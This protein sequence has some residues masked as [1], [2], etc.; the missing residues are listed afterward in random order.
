MPALF[1]AWAAARRD[2]ATCVADWHN[3]GFTVLEDVAKRAGRETAS[4][5]FIAAA[6]FFCVDIPQMGSRRRRDIE[7]RWH[8][9]AAT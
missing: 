3:L 8:A 9:A 6:Y 5:R 2:G 7:W 4:S 1:V